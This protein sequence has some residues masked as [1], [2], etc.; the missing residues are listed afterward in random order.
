MKLRARSF[1]YQIFLEFL[2]Y[3]FFGGLMLQLVISGKYLSYVTP[4]MEPYLYFTAMVMLLWAGVDLFKI[5]RPQHKVRTAH[6]FVLVI[7]ILLI[8][9][10]HRPLGSSDFSGVYMGGNNLSEQSGQHSAAQKQEPSANS[11][12]DNNISIPAENPVQNDVKPAEDMLPTDS[13]EFADPDKQIDLPGLDEANKRITVYNDDFG[14]WIFELYENMEKYKGY[15][16]VITGFVYKDPETLNEDEF[17]S[18]R[19]MMTCCVADLSLTGVV[20]KYDRA[21]QLEQESW[22]TVE[23]TLFIGEYEFDGQKYNEPQIEV[24]KVVPAEAVEGYVYPY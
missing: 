24:T 15:T 4:R 11:N 14:T 7:P 17:V 2:S 18:G 10:P 12:V 20:C 3:C 19:L 13:I 6:C 21:S 16:I 5:F 9:L 22:V 1:N 23:G 8:F